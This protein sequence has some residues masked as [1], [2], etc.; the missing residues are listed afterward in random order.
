VIPPN[1]DANKALDDNIT[2]KVVWQVLNALRSHDD[3]FDAMINKMDLTGIDRSKMEVI[4]I[5]DKVAAKAKKKVLVKVAQPLA[6]R[7]TEER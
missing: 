1:V 4:A 6:H 2:Y 7:K 3:R 5:T